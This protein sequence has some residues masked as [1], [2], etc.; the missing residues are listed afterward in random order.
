MWS[1]SCNSEER[2][3]SGSADLAFI[4][5]SRR[6]LIRGWLGLISNTFLLKEAYMAYYSLFIP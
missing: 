6:A 5:F 3:A 2:E 1:K 4:T